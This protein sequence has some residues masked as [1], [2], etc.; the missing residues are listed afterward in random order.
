MRERRAYLAW[1]RP[2]ASNQR[3]PAIRLDMLAS[4]YLLG[5]LGGS[6]KRDQV[7]NEGFKLMLLCLD[8]A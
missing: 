2:N 7:L 1:L 4:L 5:C 3:F 6:G 8:C